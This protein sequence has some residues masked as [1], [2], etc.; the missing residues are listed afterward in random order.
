[1]TYEEMQ[2]EALLYPDTMSEDER[3]SKYFEGEEID[4][5][6]F[7]PWVGQEA[8]P[9]FGYTLRQFRNSAKVQLDVQKM[10]MEQFGSG[11]VD[12]AIVIGLTGIGQA[13]GSKVDDPEEGI[14]SI[15]EYPKDIF[16][17]LDGLQIF[18][19]KNE[20]IQ[21]LIQI[22]DEFIK[23]SREECSV[24]INIPG[25]LTA[26]CSVVK[27]EQILRGLRKDSEQIHHL[28]RKTVEWNL[29]IIKYVK[30]RYGEIG[31]SISDPCTSID[32]IGY[33]NFQIFS[34]PYLQKLIYEIHKMCNMNP[35]VHICGKSNIFWQDLIKI[36]VKSFSIDN[37][38]SLQA[39][40]EKVGSE[41]CIFGNVPPVDVM[42][43][44]TIDDVIEA[45]KKCIREASD[46]PSG[47]ILT[48]GCS[49]AINT[50]RENIEALHYAVRKYGRGA[51]IG[52]MCKGILENG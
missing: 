17:R 2:E 3:M 51:Q 27:I 7:D 1:M 48:L 30:E 18:P 46:N 52:K 20:Y 24:S 32:L 16:G 50:P 14:P 33:K 42:L 11:Y 4:R 39:L 8:A 40:K 29:E 12:G 36:G 35:H 23:L 45:V 13:L 37:C 49:M 34:E 26:A 19:E 22:E 41:I 25:P 28:L 21:R 38:E 44:G 9:L 43:K 10:W 31:V 5:I 15:T 47:Y 6:N